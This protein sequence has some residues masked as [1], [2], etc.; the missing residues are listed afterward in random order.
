MPRLLASIPTMLVVAMLLTAAQGSAT[1]DYKYT[2]VKDCG[3]CHKKELIGDQLSAWKESPHAKAYET[4]KGDEAKRIAKAKGLTVAPHQADECLRCHATAHG[5]EPAQIFRKPLL[6]SDGVQCESCHGPGSA[7][8]KK[9][10]MADHEKAVA[11]GLWEPGK[12][13]KVCTTCHNPE[14]P[15]WD[16]AKGFDHAARKA[17]IEHPIPADVKGRYLEL[18]KE[19]RTRGRD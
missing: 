1:E 18:E 2:G 8:R 6:V 16:A 17:K 9:T 12:D 7:Y 13:E 4:L 3:R 11:A 10:V 14:S 15:T 5:L 19:A